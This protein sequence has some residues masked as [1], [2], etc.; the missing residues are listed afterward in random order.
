M[1]IEYRNKDELI[2][3]IDEAKLSNLSKNSTEND[4]KKHL[5]LQNVEAVRLTVKRATA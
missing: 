5:K 2:K 3:L 1:K 4:F